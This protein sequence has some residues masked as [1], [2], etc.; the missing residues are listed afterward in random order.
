M[1][2]TKEQMELLN[3]ENP[4]IVLTLE[5]MEVF[6]FFSL[7]QMHNKVVRM[8]DS[9]F[10]NTKVGVF[11]I[12]ELNGETALDFSNPDD[13]TK[14]EIKTIKLPQLAQVLSAAVTCA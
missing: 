13:W 5:D 2:I 11:T 8:T 1:E 12:D 7:G 4:E 14:V 3:S 10:G 6:A 9:F